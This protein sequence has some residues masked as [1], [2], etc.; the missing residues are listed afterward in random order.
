MAAIIAGPLAAQDASM[1]RPVLPANNNEPSPAVVMPPMAAPTPVVFQN[2]PSEIE[3]VC[4]H[5]CRLYRP[6]PM[7][8]GM[9][10]NVSPAAA[11]PNLAAAPSGNGGPTWRWYGWG[12]ANTAGTEK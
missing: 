9:Q 12:A 6:V 8:H 3:Q 1:P 4:H 5:P 2:S 7:A 10:S 11:W